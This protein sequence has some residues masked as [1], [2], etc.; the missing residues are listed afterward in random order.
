MHTVQAEEIL[1]FNLGGTKTG[2]RAH[3]VNKFSR[4]I[5]LFR[6]SHQG[7]FWKLAGATDLYLQGNLVFS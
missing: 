7:I 3:L 2:I 1:D 5:H 4:K 6:S